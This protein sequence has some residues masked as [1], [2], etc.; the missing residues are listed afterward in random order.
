MNY[1]TKNLGKY[2]DGKNAPFFLCVWNDF[3]AKLFK[4]KLWQK[5]NRQ[6]S[7]YGIT[8]GVVFKTWCFH[9]GEIWIDWKTFNAFP[10]HIYELSEEISFPYMSFLKKQ[11]KFLKFISISNNCKKI[12]KFFSVHK[13]FLDLRFRK[14]VRRFIGNSPRA[15]GNIKKISLGLRP[16]ENFFDIPLALG[17]FPIQILDPEDEKIEYPKKDFPSSFK[18]HKRFAQNNFFQKY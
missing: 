14:I 8:K 15:T 18:W 2:F 5:K 10:S 17:E 13:F 7:V 1:G 9:T 11:N 3:V 6:K 16:W 12:S 4:C